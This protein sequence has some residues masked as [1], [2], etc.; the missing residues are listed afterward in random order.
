LNRLQIETPG[1]EGRAMF[2]VFSRWQ[3]NVETKVQS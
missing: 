3:L 2:Q 1:F